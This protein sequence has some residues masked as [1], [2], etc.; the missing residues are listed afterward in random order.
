MM[1]RNLL[2]AYLSLYLWMSIFLTLSKP[3]QDKTRPTRVVIIGSTFI[4]MT[5]IHL[6]YCKNVSEYVDPYVTIMVY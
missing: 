2:E 5:K 1:G 3:G 6:I 4:R